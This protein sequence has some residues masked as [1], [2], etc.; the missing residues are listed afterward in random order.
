MPSSPAAALHFD[1]Q[2]SLRR[3]LSQSCWLIFKHRMTGKQAFLP[4]NSN[5]L[6]LIVYDSRRGMGVALVVA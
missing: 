2:T 3:K 6:P 4:S 1:P 5:Y